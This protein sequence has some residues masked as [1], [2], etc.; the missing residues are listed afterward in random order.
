MET[1]TLRTVV[2]AVGVFLT[3]GI[4]CWRIF[5][6]FR[7]DKF[8]ECASITTFLLVGVVAIYKIP[9]MPSWVV[10]AVLPLVFFF[11]WLSV[12]FG[13]QQAYCAIR[14]RKTNRQVLP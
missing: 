2:A 12:Y 1:N 14:E 7:G 3:Y 8:I 6:R 9:N 4:S 11:C 5:S 13:L 10:K